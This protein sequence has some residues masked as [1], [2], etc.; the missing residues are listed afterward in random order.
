MHV[1]KEEAEATT[2]LDLEQVETVQ[3]KPVEPVTNNE[4]L[5]E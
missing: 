3:E 5:G 2:K 1:D 4:N